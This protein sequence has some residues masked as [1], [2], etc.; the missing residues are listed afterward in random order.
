[1]NYYVQYNKVFEKETTP[2]LN[3]EKEE[4][5]SFEFKKDK[6]VIKDKRNDKEYFV[7]SNS[8]KL[9]KR[10]VIVD[11]G[12][13]T[14]A[15]IKIGH[16]ILHSIIKADEDI[17]VKSS[18][19]KIKYKAYNGRSVLNTLKVV[20]LDYTKYF[21]VESYDDNFLTI[22]SLILVARGKRIF[23]RE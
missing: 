11:S 15:T 4:I 3:E 8:K 7:K 20:N 21:E 17:F 1:M 13:N 14:L 12:D 6:L 10:Y 22:I 19:Q 18:F 9:N 2:I 16:K 5:G 23:V